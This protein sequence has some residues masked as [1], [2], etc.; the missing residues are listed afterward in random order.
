MYCSSK[1]SSSKTLFQEQQRSI[2]GRADRPAKSD[3]GATERRL[4][5]GRQKESPVY[6]VRP[7]MEIHE[8]DASTVPL[9]HTGTVVYVAF[10]TQ[11]V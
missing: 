10:S 4:I 2:H 9:D 7:K 3:A 8:Q 11:S 1:I 6:P 5:P